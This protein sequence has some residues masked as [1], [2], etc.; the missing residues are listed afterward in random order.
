MKKT[1]TKSVPSFRWV[2]EDRCEQCKS[3]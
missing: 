2:V 1:V 3:K